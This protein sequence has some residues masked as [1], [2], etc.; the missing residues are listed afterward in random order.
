MYE[1]PTTTE[2]ATINQ[3][4]FEA[5]LPKEGIIF[6]SNDGSNWSQL[7]VFSNNDPSPR[8]INI[9]SSTGYSYYTL[10]VTKTG[11]GAYGGNVNI[12]EIEFYSNSEL[13]STENTNGVTSTGTLGTD[14]ITTWKIPTDASDTMY[15]ASDGSAN[16]GGKINVEVT[17]YEEK[18]YAAN[19][20]ALTK[21]IIG[22]AGGQDGLRGTGG[23]EGTVDHYSAWAGAGPLEA[24]GAQKAFNGTLAD[25][26]DTWH[27]QGSEVNNWVSFTFPYDVTITKYKIWTRPLSN[28]YPPKAWE[29]RL[30]KENVNYVESDITTYTVIHD[31]SGQVLA[32]WPG[33][34]GTSGSAQPNSI[35]ND[36]ERLEFHVPTENQEKGR[37]IIIYVKEKNGTYTSI[38]ELAYYG[39]HD[40]TPSQYTNVSQFAIDSQ[41]QPTLNLYRD[42]VYKFDQSDASNVGQ[43]LFVSNNLDGRANIG[44]SNASIQF[45][46]Q[47][48]TSNSSQD[49][50]ASASTTQDSPGAYAAFDKTT[51]AFWHSGYHKYDYNNNGHAFTGS[52]YS[53][54]ESIYG[55]WIKIHFQVESFKLKELVV[56]ARD[57]QLNRGPDEGYV[58][59]SLDGSTWSQLVNF[60][61]IANSGGYNGYQNGVGKTINV[62]ATT[63]YSYY[64]LLT[65][66]LSGN[67]NNI[68]ISR[69][70]LNSWDPSTLILTENTAGVTSTGTLGTDLVTRW[71]V[72]T[73]A[74]DTMY[75]ASDGSANI[76]G[77][78]NILYSTPTIV[79]LTASSVVNVI[80]SGGNKYR[81]NGDTTY[82]ANKYY[83]LGAG[84]Y[85]LTGV[86]SGHPIAILNA[87]KTSLISYTGDIANKSNKTV[88]GTSYDFY[89]GTVTVTVSGDFGSVSVYCFHHGYMGGENLL[90]YSSSCDLP[91][92]SGGIETQYGGYRIHTFTT[93]EVFTVYHDIDVTYLIVAGG[94]G[95]GKSVG[96]GGGGGGFLEGS[97][98][99]TPG[100]YTVV[101]GSG[102]TGMTSTVTIGSDGGDSSA[103]G[104][105]AIGGGA[106]TG[107]VVANGNPGG[108]GGRD[109]GSG[110]GGSRQNNL[111]GQGT[112]GQGND[113]GN[114]SNYA[115]AFGAGGGG[116]A[117]TAGSNGTNISGGNGGDGKSSIITGASVTYAGGG[118]GSAVV[119]IGIG[120]TGGGGDGNGQSGTDGLGGGGG[121]DDGNGNGGNG[122][123]GIVIIR[124]LL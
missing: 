13:I 18:T 10:L 84:T 116:G 101:V 41:L 24:Y 26:F 113:G 23:I 98:S 5:K 69:I 92:S 19:F 38:G 49:C 17:P 59:G 21:N 97:L 100:T 123:D 110:G 93:S 115:N 58:F 124:Y 27:S 33:G 68:N 91:S 120:G 121:G 54:F 95:G 56:Y 105:T 87:G 107:Q 75:Y 106:G 37:M 99:L 67:D 82:V 42:S 25:T 65:T 3:H 114:G 35:D 20:S 111:G 112:N 48:M 31:V 96:S 47:A 109:G 7:C 30:V 60:T 11:G 45:P 79:C 55:E 119:S 77:T 16:A 122:G 94:G 28:Y 29:L 8:T 86:P 66:K 53:S 15:Y 22:L 12:A 118:G 9:N 64:V 88:S 43:R 102:G 2:Q 50:V 4:L 81:F 70:D 57:G 104:V 78:I 73:D 46:R 36:T 51:V 103:L 72:P 80:S 71:R 62:S 52:S 40:N 44:G 6:G 83:G 108:D 74:S 89:H 117:G 63:E 61:G 1:R 34:G 85:T 39:Y 32:N 90:R 76:G 14:L